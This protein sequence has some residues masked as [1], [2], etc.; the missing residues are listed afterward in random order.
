MRLGFMERLMS[1]SWDPGS[2]SELS[3]A[4]KVGG[5]AGSSP[6][7]LGAQPQSF[8]LQTAPTPQNPPMLEFWLCDLSHFGDSVSPSVKGGP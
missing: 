6:G 5:A 7:K 3:S 4:G 2:H 1:D 8:R